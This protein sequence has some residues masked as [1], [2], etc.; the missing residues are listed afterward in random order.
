MVALQFLKLSGFDNII[1]T[2]SKSNSDLV[3]SFGATHVIDRSLPRSD[4]VKQIKSIA[5][6]LQYSWDCIG[7]KETNTLAA[8]SFRP[9]GGEI[10]SSLEVSKEVLAEYTNV[11]GRSIYSGPSA[12]PESATKI[13]SKMTH[14]LQDGII[15]PLPYKVHDGGLDNIYDALQAVKK[16]SGYKVVVHPQE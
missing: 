15:K 4:Q 11:M 9:Q 12:H 5:P 10:V 1:T 8:Q 14:A 3:K 2:A 6:D 16:V 13:W 7:N